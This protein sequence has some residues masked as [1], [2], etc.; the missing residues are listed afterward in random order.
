MSVSHHPHHNNFLPFY[1]NL[2]IIPLNWCYLEFPCSVN[3]PC[4]WEFLQSSSRAGSAAAQAG[5][6]WKNVTPGVACEMITLNAK[7]PAPTSCAAT[8]TAC[9]HSAQ[10]K[11]NQTQAGQPKDRVS[12]VGFIHGSSDTC[13]RRYGSKAR[14]LSGMQQWNMEKKKS[15]C[16]SYQQLSS[17]AT[18]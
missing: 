15:L 10:Q 7:N 17:S 3:V 11:A 5:K 18:V 14:D 4:H 8:I 9:Y 12:P 2:P 13:V 16:S 6:G 1:L